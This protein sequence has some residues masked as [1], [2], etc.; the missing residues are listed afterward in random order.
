VTEEATTTQGGI[1]LVSSA[2]A[3]PTTG[4]IEAVGDGRS[5]KA[6]LLVQPSPPLPL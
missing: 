3:K 5:A 2:V 4:S 1:V 6:R